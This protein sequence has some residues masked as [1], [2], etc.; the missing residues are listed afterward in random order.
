MTKMGGNPGGQRGYDGSAS[1]E[2]K[3]VRGPLSLLQIPDAEYRGL[4]EA[5]KKRLPSYRID[6]K[7][8]FAESSFA[9][10]NLPPILLP[11]MSLDSPYEPVTVEPVGQPG[12]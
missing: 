9:S 8:A 2:T 5:A 1:A 10:G 6:T 3:A 11:Q 12:P 4:F 7:G